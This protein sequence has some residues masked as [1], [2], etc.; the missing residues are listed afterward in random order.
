MDPSIF[1][2]FPELPARFRRK[3]KNTSVAAKYGAA[4]NRKLWVMTI[5]DAHGEH[6]EPLSGSNHRIW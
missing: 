5:F 2:L 3:D 6:H 4:A 1:S